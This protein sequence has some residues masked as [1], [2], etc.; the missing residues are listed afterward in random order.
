[1]KIQALRILAIVIGVLA[2]GYGVFV[3]FFERN[4]YIKSTAVIEQIEETF[5]G[6][7][8]E[9]G[10][11]YA[12]DVYIYFST[13]DGRTVHTKADNYKNSYTVGKRIPIW[14]NPDNPEQVHGD[15]RLLGVIL[16]IVGPLVAAGSGYAFVQEKRR[17]NPGNT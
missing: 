15:N 17:G 2:L 10:S 3:T 13:T 11:D 14:Y 7:D 6:V 16:M 12:Y 4:G 5:T 9:G 8:S 1:M